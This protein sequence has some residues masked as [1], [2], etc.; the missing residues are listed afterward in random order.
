MNLFFSYPPILWQLKLVELLFYLNA[1]LISL[2][3]KV[4]PTNRQG[5]TQQAVAAEELLAIL[6]LLEDAP[7]L[8]LFSFTKKNGRASL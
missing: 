7:C 3:I 1:N 2:S 4:V 5:W 6:A 8:S